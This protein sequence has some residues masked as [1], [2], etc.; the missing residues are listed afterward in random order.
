M[1]HRRRG[2]ARPDRAPP[3][4][5]NARRAAASSSPMVYED[6]RR[7]SPARLR[8]G[9]HRLPGRRPRTIRPLQLAEKLAAATGG[10][11]D[12][13]DEASEIATEAT[14]PKLAS[15]WWARLGALVLGQ[16]RPRRLRACRRC[17]ARSSSTPR[18]APR[19]RHSPRRSASSRSGRSSPTR[20]AQHA[21]IETEPSV[22]VDLL[23]RPRRSAARPSSR[24]PRP[25]SRPTRRRPTSTT[26]ATTRS[27]RSSGCT[28]ATSAWANLAKVL[29]RR[30]EIAAGGRRRRPRRR[31]PPRARDPARREARRSRGRDRALRGRRRRER[32][33]RDGA[34]GPGRSL[35]QDRPH[36]RLPAHDGA[37]RPGRARGREARDPA[38]ARRRARGPRSEARDRARTRSCSPPI[39]TRTTRTAASSACSKRRGELVRAGRSCYAAPH[40]G[41]EDAGPAASSSTSSRADPRARARRSTPGD[42]ARCS[43]CSRSTSTN[44]TAL[45]VAAPALRHAPRR[46]TAPSTSW[47]ATPRSRATAARALYAEAG[48]IAFEQLLDPEVAQR[49]LDKALA[50]DAEN[51]AAL[52]V[53]APAPRDARRTGAGRRACCC[54]PRPRSA[55]RTERDRAAVA[56]GAARRSAARTIRPVRSSS[57]SACSS[58]IRITS[59]PASASPTSSSPPSAGTMRCRVLEMLARQAEG[60]STQ[61]RARAP[62]GAARQGVRGAAPHRE[63]GAPLPARGRGRPGQPRRRDRP[64]RAC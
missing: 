49:H 13:V 40:R 32:Q 64:G 59:R 52:K 20:C 12:L 46:S 57:T 21:E 15:K 36:R 23:H 33:R 16:A 19:S 14:D 1:G 34:Q 51:Y 31:D 41:R 3:S 55:S 42:R 10:W 39:R 62:R 4:P 17:V 9:D 45:S 29:E 54:A 22:K 26:T 24:R 7:R 5:R 60:E 44:R 11:A 56:C 6:R 53:L 8:G 18:T 27:P 50:L 48:K 35:R 37:P 63:G 61:P 38:Q 28:A 43:T 47:S 25:R 58:S 30:A 2:P